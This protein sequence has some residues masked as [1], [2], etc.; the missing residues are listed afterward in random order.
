MTDKYQTLLIFDLDGTRYGL[1]STKVLESVWLPEL[2]PI[3]EAPPWVI[4]IFNLRGQIVP[5]TDLNLRFGHPA[6]HLDLSDQVVVLKNGN[7]IMGLIVADVLEVIDLL[8]DSIAPSPHFELS[9]YGLNHLAAGIADIDEDL[10]TLIDV[11]QLTKHS[12]LLDLDETTSVKSSPNQLYAETDPE[13]R[14]R[15]HA[16][17]FALRQSTTEEDVPLLGLAVI[18]MSGEY[19]GI[20]LTA[21]QE[22]CNIT[23]LRPIPCCPPHIL[24]AMSLRGKLL[25]LIDPSR[26]LNLPPTSECSKAVIA[27]T[28]T[29]LSIGIAVH[30]V[31]DVIYLKHEQLH[32]PPSALREQCGTEIVGT[33]AY[34]DK[35]IIVLDLPK[36]LEREDW[37]VDETI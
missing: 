22:F 2:T 12:K 6:R 32:A 18:E 30:E 35:T 8:S 7:E 11:D 5:V 33:A 21:V 28:S 25:T 15:F 9:P 4:G 26:A 27:N 31:H 13:I 1:D 17:A 29:D 36:L 19:F 16:R 37:V 24:G 20:K 3:E 14:A 34:E 23:Q 10:V